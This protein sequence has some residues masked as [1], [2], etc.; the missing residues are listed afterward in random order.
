MEGIHREREPEGGEM[1]RVIVRLLC[2]HPGMQTALKAL[3]YLLHLVTF[4]F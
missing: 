4:R 2:G 3:Q 1:K